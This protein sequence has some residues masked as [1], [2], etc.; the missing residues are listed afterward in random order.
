MKIYEGRRTSEGP[1]VEIINGNG[2]RRLLPQRQDRAENDAV[3]P[4]T[5]SHRPG[6]T[7]V[8]L[9]VVITIILVISAIALPSILS[10]LSHRQVSEAARILQSALVGARDAAIHNNAA[11]G[12][13]LLPDPAFPLV[14]LPSGQ[15]DP[16][17]PLA[18]NRIIPIEWAPEYT[19]GLVNPAAG[20]GHFPGLAASKAWLLLVEAVVNQTTTPGLPNAPTSFFWNIRVGDKIQINGVG[21]WYTV[22]GPLVIYPASPGS[23]G[24]N[25]E[26]YVNVGPPDSPSPIRA[27]QGGVSVHPEFLYLVNGRDDNNNGWIDEGCDGVD[28]NN[29]GVIDEPAEWEQ[30]SWLA[31][32]TTLDATDL[33]YTI[34]RRPA[35]SINA[36]EV[37]LP[38]NVVIDL[39]TWATSQERSRLPVNPWTGYVD[40]LLA[41]NGMAVPITI[42]STPACLGL[43]GAFFHFWLAER[44]DVVP[45]SP[46]AIAPPYLLVGNIAPQGPQATPYAGPRIQGEYRLVTLFCRTGRLTTADD[47]QFDN[48]AVP[49]SGGA[50][51]PSLPFIPAQQQER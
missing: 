23:P 36:R 35:P 51:N 6:L 12:I 5:S 25:S 9:L 42:Y 38:S 20:P 11:A 50:Y 47:L 22:V 33:P 30:E 27:T 40:V 4:K 29:N 48:P 13:R 44:S 19:E 49:L 24:Q 32:P 2:A 37:A 17:Q 31:S 45:P 7:L 26:L 46:A 14:Y 43:G 16:T 1:I 41:P 28:N 18:A 39:T 10:A 34:R 15:L 8:E 3:P 21:T